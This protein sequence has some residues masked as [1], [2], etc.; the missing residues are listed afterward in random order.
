MAGEFKRRAARATENRALEEN[1]RMV[2]RRHGGTRRETLAEL[3]NLEQLR[4]RL[5][6][7]KEDVLSRHAELLAE[8]IRNVEVLG[9]TVH[10]AADAVAAREIVAGIAAAAGAKVIVKGKSMTGEEVG[11][12]S[13]L[14]AR[15]FEVLETDLGEYIIQLAGQGPSHIVL[16]AIHMTKAEIAALFHEKLGMPLTDD[17]EALTKKAR[18]ILREKFLAADVGSTG[19]NALVAENG[20]V[21]LVENEGNIRLSTTL[22]RVHV[23]LVG[24]EKI[25]PRLDD[26]AVLLK[27]LPRNATGQKMSGYVSFIRGGRRGAERD[28]AREFHLVLLDNGRSRLMADPV[29]REALKCIRCGACLNNCPVY[30]H[31]GGH[32]YGSTYPGPIGAMIT[33]D[34]GAGDADDWFLPF[35]S[36]LCGACT[37]ACPAHIPIHKIL[38]ELRRRAAAAG[39]AGVGEGLAFRAWSEAWSRPAGYRLSNAAVRIGGRMLAKDGMIKVLPPPFGGWTRVRDLPAPAARPFRAEWVEP[40]AGKSAGGI[41]VPASPLDDEPAPLVE[42]PLRVDAPRPGDPARFAR[43]LTLRK[44]TVIEAAGA[45]EAR[46]ALARILKDFAGASL[47]RWDHPE[48]T[49]LGLDELAAAAGVTVTTAAADEELKPIAA[50]AAVGVTAVDGA[51]AATGTIVLFTGGGTERGISLLPPAHVALLRRDKIYEDTED[52]VALAR[53]RGPDF[54]GLTLVTGPSMT[55]DIELIPVLGVH[56][57]G[58]LIVIV[59]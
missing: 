11:L 14:I 22:P 57:P 41:A 54:R 6:A 21:V 52:L 33:R 20:M 45:D 30:Q 31:I 59:Y 19:A 46:A 18:E 42:K 2:A 48:L 10:R 27:L 53:G 49:A 56:G 35:A 9:G 12:N 23:A 29:M 16:P 8:L 58:R 4:H 3:G 38:I 13:A 34:L 51:S 37:E 43:E 36:S 17:A 44:A 15:G 47:V 5:N 55:G 28:G 50:A 24:I 1:L 32:A 26:V 40:A 39:L 25:L 7:V